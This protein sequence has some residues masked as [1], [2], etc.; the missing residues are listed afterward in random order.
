MS[1]DLQSTATI[2]VS[3]VKLECC[4]DF[5]INSDWTLPPAGIVPQYVP[6]ILRAVDWAFPYDAQPPVLSRVRVKRPDGTWATVVR[7][8]G[9]HI[10]MPDGSWQ[11][12]D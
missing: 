5:T 9:V 4:R 7:V 3:D 2:I 11:V 8:P 1:Y 6:S 12:I 10:Q